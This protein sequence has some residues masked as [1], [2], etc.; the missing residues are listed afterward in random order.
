MP[1]DTTGQDVRP[2]A[3][4]LSEADI[5]SLEGALLLDPEELDDAIFAVMPGPSGE[6]IALYDYDDLARIDFE[7]QT[8]DWKQGDRSDEPP[9]W[10]DAVANVDH[11]MIG[12]VDYFV[13]SRAPLIVSPVHDPIDLE[14]A[15]PGDVVELDGKSYLR[16]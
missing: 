8:R 4:K 7:L 11:N 16:I 12:A 3:S 6:M 2:R 14:E 15:E 1:S 5:K 13:G 9:I 10:E